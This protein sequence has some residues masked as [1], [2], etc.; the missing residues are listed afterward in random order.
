M[1]PPAPVEPPPVVEPPPRTFLPPPFAPAPATLH[2][3]TRAQ[4]HNSVTDLLGDVDVPEDI[5]VDTPIYGFAAI[6]A[7]QQAIAPRAAEQY[8]AAALDLARQV[9][10]DQARRDAFVR[11]TPSLRNDSCAREIAGSFGRRAF[12]RDLT[13]DEVDRFSGLAVTIAASLSD[14]YK[15][16]EL[17]VAAILQAPQFLYRVE[18]G[19][20]DPDDASRRRYT[21]DEMASRLSYL[22]TNTTPDDTLLEVAA[23]DGLRDAAGVREQAMRLLGTERARA[24]IR[25]FFGEYLKLDR[26]DLLNKDPARFPQMTATLGASMREEILRVVESIVFDRDVDIRTM[27]DT[28][29]TFVNADLARLYN[30]P[31]VRA[32]DGFVEHERSGNAPRAGVLTFA[33]FL[34]LNAH[35]TVT[36]PT[37]RGRFIRQF[38]LCQDIPPPPPDVMTTVPEP[39]AT[40]EQQTLRQ[41]LEALHLDNPSCAGC[42][43]LMDPLGFGLESFDAI[44]AYRTTDNGLPVDPRGQLDGQPFST[45]RE[46]SARVR[47]HRELPRCLTR[48]AYR[49]ASGHLETAGEEAAIYEM[50]RAFEQSGYS[51]SALLVALVTSDG[52]RYAAE[53]QP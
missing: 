23:Q 2:R 1:D 24:A 13:A 44:G 7:S 51:F 48:M 53:V 15:G 17:M 28:N 31:G 14:P 50:V 33:G 9:F 11:C 26:L 22:I 32:A 37:L 19:E 25:N 27:F 40:P 29:R 8:E 46:L 10:E 36:S 35:A 3:L 34:A 30:I 49:Y 38:L 12:R 45:A 6:G 18:L 47:D 20:P 21:S 16:L 5:E 39:D 52:F 42:H 43:T 41:R 4:Y